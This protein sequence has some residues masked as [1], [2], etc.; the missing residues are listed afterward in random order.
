MAAQDPVYDCALLKR[1]LPAPSPSLPSLISPNLSSLPPEL[2]LQIAK[3]IALGEPGYE[4][5]DDFEGQ[6]LRIDTAVGGKRPGTLCRLSETC[7]EWRADVAVTR[8]STSHRDFLRDEPLPRYKQHDLTISP[9]CF[10]SFFPHLESLILIFKRFEAPLQPP[11][12]P[13]LTRLAL[14]SC[15]MLDHATLEPFRAAPLEE[16]YIHKLP[17]ALLP[18][19]CSSLEPYALTLRTLRF[20]R[21]VIVVTGRVRNALVARRRLED[22]QLWCI[23]HGIEATLPQ[24]VMRPTEHEAS[25]IPPQVLPPPVQ[26]VN[27]AGTA[28][29][30]T[31]LVWSLSERS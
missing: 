13:R 17:K 5:L 3:E 11:H 21:G 1:T 20:G 15:A 27:S 22:A 24:V 14:F 31:G 9:T 28:N 4:P 19:L 30:A 23:E 16:L 25:A 26:P 7:R 10:S 2:K 12:L 18:V 29:R 6:T 8:D